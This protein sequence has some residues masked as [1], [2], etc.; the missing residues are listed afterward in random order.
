MQII[1][2][3]RWLL[4]AT[5]I[6]QSL[7]EQQAGLRSTTRPR[8]VIQD[9]VGGVHHCSRMEAHAAKGKAGM[10]PARF[11]SSWPVRVGIVRW[12]ITVVNSL[13]RMAAWQ[14]A[15]PACADMEALTLVQ[16]LASCSR[17]GGRSAVVE[18]VAGAPA[19]QLD[20]IGQSTAQRGGTGKTSWVR[21][22]V[23]RSIRWDQRT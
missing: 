22:H 3:R 11:P 8:I 4:W 9:H 21:V 18:Q 10:S 19:A 13:A 12:Q 14:R 6:S 2:W 5:A 17:S 15:R 16:P 1:L 20:R 23:A 7:R